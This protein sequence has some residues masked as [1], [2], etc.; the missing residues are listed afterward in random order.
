M[1]EHIEDVTLYRTDVDSTIVKRSVMHH[2]V[3]GFIDDGMNNCHIKAEQA[4][5]NDSDESHAIFLKFIKD[6]NNPAGGSSS[7][8]E[9]SGL[10]EKKPISPHVVCFSQAIDV[11]VSKTF[12]ICCLKWADIG[13]LE[14]IEVVKGDLQHLFVLD[15]NDQAMNTH[16]KK[17]NDPEE[18]P[19]ILVGR[20]EDWH[21]LCDHYIS[22][23]FQKK[24]LEL[25]SQP[26]PDGSQPLSGDEI[27]ET[28]LGRQPSYSKGTFVSL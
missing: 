12:P 26:T 25:Q 2:V 16:F 28:M 3:D 20:I 14:Y 7:V 8:S 11:Y 9:N 22:H 6:L 18:T 10:D 1:D 17:Y 19:H 21:Y 15:F 5:A 4:M 24:M 13:R 23:A 27:C